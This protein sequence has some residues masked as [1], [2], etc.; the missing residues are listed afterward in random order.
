MAQDPKAAFEFDWISPYT[1]W[2]FGLGRDH[3]FFAQPKSAP[4]LITGVIERASSPMRHDAFG[5]AAPDLIVPPLWRGLTQPAFV[6]FILG[7]ATAGPNVDTMTARGLDT[8]A[9][10][11]GGGKLKHVSFGLP[12]PTRFIQDG[13]LSQPAIAPAA[14]CDTQRPIVVLGVIDDGIGFANRSFDDAD[15]VTRIDAAWVQGV[16]PSPNG[17][18]RFGRELGRGDIQALRDTYG[19]D[20]DA[21]YRA[22]GLAPG[23]SYDAGSLWS[24]LAHGTHVLG[25]AA[26]DTA[27]AQVRVVT[28]DLPATTSWDTTGPGKDLFILS[29]LHFIF[30]RAEQIAEAHGL[31]HVPVVVNMSYGYAGGAHRGTGWLEAAMD[32]LVTARRS[33]SPTALV[34][35]AGNNFLD[36]MHAR[37]TVE[38]GGKSAP[39]PWRLMPDDRSS[40]FVEIWLPDGVGPEHVEITLSAPA[41]RRGDVGQVAACIGGQS[42]ER[43]VVDPVIVDGAAVGQISFDQPR[44]L[45]WRAL[46]AVAPT[47]TLAQP[48]PAGLWHIDISDLRRGGAPITLSA[49]IQRDIS[50]GTSTSGA[51]QSYFDEFENARW[52][53][54]GF[55]KTADTDGARTKRF[56]SLSG[57][58]SG[59]TALVVGASQG[60]PLKAADYSAAGPED[61]AHPRVS[62]VSQTEASSMLSGVRSAGPRSGSSLAMSGTS[63]AVPLVSRAVV[64]AFLTADGADVAAAEAQNYLDLLDVTATSLPETRVGRGV[65]RS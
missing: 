49:W 48:A 6:P 17:S 16:P 11:A 20:E 13:P 40:N 23:K 24:S 63:A 39:L 58:A 42:V 53:R 37:E 3:D 25:V 7:S 62:L 36:A 45:Q 26:G 65:L 47:E 61:G 29:A 30:E 27:D 44:G 46:I 19:P 21:M 55:W 32:E 15:G 57:M 50:Y 28:V 31:D 60:S 54:R 33:K 18:V 51:R 5:S 34:L 52:T 8:W 43:C 14:S 22:V 2:M 10:G 64:D 12:I 41:K 56:G 59:R 4:A 1:A 38:A 9:S 35:P